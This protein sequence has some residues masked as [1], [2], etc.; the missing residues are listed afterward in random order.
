MEWMKKTACLRDQPTT[1]IENILQTEPGAWEFFH[2]NYTYLNQAMHSFGLVRYHQTRL[3]K[4]SFCWTGV[5]RYWIWEYPPIRVFVNNR[6]GIVFEVA[7]HLTVDEALNAFGVYMEALGV[8]RASSLRL[9]EEFRLDKQG[10]DA[11]KGHEMHFPSL[12]AEELRRF[13]LRFCDGHIWTSRHSPSDMGLMFLPV[14]FGCLSVPKQT[15]ERIFSKLMPDPGKEP[16]GSPRPEAPSFPPEPKRPDEPEPVQ[17]DPA[18]VSEIQFNISWD[19]KSNKELDAYYE[20]IKRQNE[21]LQ[22]AFKED[23]QRWEKEVEEWRA[24]CDRLT[25][26]HQERISEWEADNEDFLREHRRW[27]EARARWEAV[28]NGVGAQFLKD[29]GCVWADSEMDQHCGRSINGKPVFMDCH[30]MN[31]QDFERAMQACRIEEERRKKI[32]V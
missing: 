29:L 4:Q 27:V 24:L 11:A 28:C 21:A 20:E 1:P 9:A 25:A 30:L 15:Q 22:D 8:S 18:R 23:L 14:A 2:R 31:L 6:K 10:R 7:P 19:D 12:T 16:Q 32:V 13:V 5:H 17:A 3:G 26:D